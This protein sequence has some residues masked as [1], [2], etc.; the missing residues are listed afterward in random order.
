[1]E[2]RTIAPEEVRPFLA[3]LNL[4]FTSTEENEAEIAHEIERLEPDRLFAAVEDGAI[5][6]CAG[7]Y[8][9]DV[10]VPGGRVAPM[11]GITTVGVL[12]THR[13]RGITRELLGRLLAQARERGEPIAA[14]FASQAAIYGRFGFGLATIGAELDVLVERSGFVVGYQRHGRARL[15]AREEALPAMKTVYD[16]VCPTRPGM[17]RLD[18]AAFAW[19]HF[20]GDK[21]EDRHLYVVHEDDDGRPDAYAVYRAQHEWPDSLP[22]LELKARHVLGSTPQG[23][24]DV[25]R[26]LLDVD[27][28]H[29]VKTGDRPLDE[30]LLWLLEEPR[31]MRGKLVDGLHAR[32]VD[33]AA[34][35]EARGYAGQGRLVLEVADP[36]LPGGGGTFALAVEEGVA[37][38]V[39]T[40]E[41]EPELRCGTNAVGST[42]FG[43]STWRQLARA[44]AVQAT[45]ETLARAD[46]LFSSDP[47]PWSP[48]FF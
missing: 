12:P 23:T 28:V 25:W 22:H 16:A 30:P 6:G 42:F 33:V 11:A 47:A 2:F 5:V 3:T 27:L 40:D 36:F 10:T 48:W 46:A 18:D 4:A 19:M 45:A 9:F 29:R 20:E 7:A 35:L 26:Y 1:M 24:A 39:R 17:L 34:A 13:R 32:P 14:L 38:C 44:G 43:G 15:L 31:A 41:L 37:T 8:T 21:P